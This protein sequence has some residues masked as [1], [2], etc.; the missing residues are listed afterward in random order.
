[1][2]AEM[3][4][5]LHSNGDVHATEMKSAAVPAAVGGDGARPRNSAAK[6]KGKKR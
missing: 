1:V 5:L 3:S 6:A 2:R 4:S